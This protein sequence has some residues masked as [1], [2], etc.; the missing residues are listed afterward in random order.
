MVDIRFGI[1]TI[2][3]RENENTEQLYLVRTT[4][5]IEAIIQNK[6]N[7]TEKKLNCEHNCNKLQFESEFF[8]VF[9]IDQWV[10]NSFRVICHIIPNI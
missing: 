1:A 6:K 5:Y 8:F 7:I 2:T 4:F 3:K 10:W 9:A